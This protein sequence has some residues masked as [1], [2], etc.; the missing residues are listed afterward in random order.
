MAQRDRRFSG[1]QE[2]GHC[3]NTAPMEIVREYS[4]VSSHED[5][6]SGYQWESGEVFELLLCPACRKVSLR[7]YFWH[8][9]MDPSEVEFRILYPSESR[10]ILG[11]PKALESAYEEALRVR[12]IAPNAYGVLLGR[13]LELV[14]EDRE[15][16]GKTLH[17]RLQYLAANGEIPDKL[18][19]VA[20]GLKNLRNVGAHAGYAELTPA[21]I[22]ILDDLCRAI[23]GYIYEA[24]TL[25]ETAEKHLKELK[26]RGSKRSSKKRTPAKKA[27]AKK[28]AKAHS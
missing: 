6:R 15:A 27:V 8:D 5:P 18:V 12:A 20:N 24:P 10:G 21:E 19:R 14:C 26:G 7:A 2:C 23:L 1:D 9:A 28:K 22:P 17:L 4:Q 3:G 11:L 13:V 16:Q 25:A